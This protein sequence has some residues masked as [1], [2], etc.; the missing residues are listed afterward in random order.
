MSESDIQY[1]G[2]SATLYCI[3]YVESELGLMRLTG[4]L[5]EVEKDG[6]SVADCKVARL[7]RA[8]IVPT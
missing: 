7:Q 8:Y 4:K 3:Q 6:L 5:I 2:S 1:H